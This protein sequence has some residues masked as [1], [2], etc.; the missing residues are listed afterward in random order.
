MMVISDMRYELGNI[1]RY[2][3]AANGTC[4]ENASFFS[5]VLKEEI[6]GERLR[7]AACTALKNHPLFRTKVK[8]RKQYYLETN[9]APVTVT[10]S[11]AADRPKVFGRNTNGYPW[12]LCYDGPNICFEWCHVITD[13]KGAIAFF[14]D[15][16]NAYFGF[17][18]DYAASRSLALGYE[19][20]YNKKIR[21]FG[22][23]RQAK[24]F[25]VRSLPVIKNGFKCQS[26]V[27]SVRT[28]DVLQVAKKNDATPV[29]V[30]V[31]LLCRAVR[32]RIPKGVKNRNVRCGIAVDCRKPSEVDTAHNFILVK[33][34]T[35]T[36]R[37]D[38]FDLPMLST[39]YRA[40]L[41]LF[42]DKD[43]IAAACTEMIKQTDFLYRLRPLR[44]QRFVMKLVAK[45]VKNTMQNVGF[46]YLGKVPFSKQL[47]ERIETFEF[48]TWP[49][50]GYCCVA[51]VDFNGT[52]FLDICENYADK[53]VVPAFIET[54]KGYGLQ[55]RIEKEELFEQAA[56]RVNDEL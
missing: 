38:L 12:R 32:S 28:A 15:I 26:H 22:Q 18:P 9:D 5:A 37:F 39:I 36:D 20:L 1:D 41:D 27:L 53:G 50:I 56:M 25:D 3:I 48:R 52:L 17:S 55:V 40:M 16:M 46:T 31:P 13:G 42:V 35:Y 24:G 44:L 11:S 29:A 8:Y 10:H 4:M 33:P 7:D 19:S 45:A 49:D 47:C 30:L 51:A 21:S 54:C 23:V 34:I 43:N 2:A 14:T 6:D